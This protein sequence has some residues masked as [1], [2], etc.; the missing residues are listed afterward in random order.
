MSD[1]DLIF[2]TSYLEIP[3]IVFKKV[4]LQWQRESNASKIPQL[5]KILSDRGYGQEQ[6]EKITHKNFERVI[7]EILK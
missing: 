2:V 4:K 6:I 7:K 3:P 5:I 1:S